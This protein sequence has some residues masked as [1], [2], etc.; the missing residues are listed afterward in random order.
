MLGG[1]HTPKPNRALRALP[2]VLPYQLGSSYA[3]ETYPNSMQTFTL[4]CLWVSCTFTSIT[5]KFTSITC[6]FTSITCRFT[7]ITLISI[8]TALLSLPVV[9]RLTCSLINYVNICYVGYGCARDLPSCVW[10]QSN[11]YNFAKVS[12]LLFWCSCFGLSFG[13]VLQL[14]YSVHF[15]SS[16]QHRWWA[17]SRRNIPVYKHARI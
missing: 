17:V 8:I 4:H 1:E 3:P 5:W 6:R 16:T 10:T 9:R 14:Y 12:G 7:S 15:A 11:C 2:Q 13:K